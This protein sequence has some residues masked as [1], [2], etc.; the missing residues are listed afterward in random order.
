MEYISRVYGLVTDNDPTT[1]NGQVFLVDYAFMLDQ[2]NLNIEEIML[3]DVFKTQL[4]LSKTDTVG[5][6]NRNVM[7]QT[8]TMSHDNLSAILSYSYFIKSN[9]RFEIWKYLLKHLG[10]YDNTQGKSKQLTRFLPFNPANFFI[11]GLCAESFLA[12]LFLPFFIINFLITCAKPKDDTSGKILL[13]I[14]LYSLKNNFIINLFYKYYNKRMIAQY[15]IEYKTELRKLY[16]GGNSADFPI[17]KLLG[18]SNA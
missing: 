17:N 12:Y 4:E 8:R 10:T 15:G 11:W 13:N 16:H 7:L 1:E 9:H 18:I 3:R 2:R 6:Y 14:E 5:L